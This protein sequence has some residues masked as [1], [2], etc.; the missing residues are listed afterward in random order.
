MVTVCPLIRTAG[1]M[2]KQDVTGIDQKYA[3]TEHS[4]ELKQ[5]GTS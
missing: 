4:Y 3:V 2:A 5:T 1:R